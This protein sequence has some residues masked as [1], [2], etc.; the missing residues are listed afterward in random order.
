MK[1]SDKPLIVDSLASQIK[2]AKSV[3]VLNYQGMP[4]K[5]LNELRQK[6][7]EAGG[8]FAVSKNTLIKRALEKVHK[9]F[10]TTSLDT[11]LTGPTAIILSQNDEVAPLQVLGKSIDD[12]G[13]PKLKFG[14][15]DGNV[16]SLEKLL[17]LSHLPGKKALAA[18]LLGALIAPKYNMVGVLN[19]NLQKLVY[20]LDQKAKAV[21]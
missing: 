14:I 3:T 11:L 2:E 15:F 19:G 18:Q 16:L 7:R 21:N 6:V 12:S 5:Q 10:D 17:T 4:N 1:K 13:L 9:I 20:I 8:I